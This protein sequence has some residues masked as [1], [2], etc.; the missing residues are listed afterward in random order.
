MLYEKEGVCRL[1]IEDCNLIFRYGNSV[2]TG[3]GEWA[4]GECCFSPNG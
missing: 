1:G 4:D 2:L 3:K